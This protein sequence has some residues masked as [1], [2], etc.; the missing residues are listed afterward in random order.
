MDAKYLEKLHAGSQAKQHKSKKVD[1]IGGILLSETELDKIFTVGFDHH[2][3]ILFDHSP[4]NFDK[5]LKNT[6]ELPVVVK[7]K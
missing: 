1:L 5:T 2:L 6:F 7:E 3:F 4:S